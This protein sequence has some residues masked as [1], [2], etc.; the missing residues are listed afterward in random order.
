LNNQEIINA[1]K[2]EDLQDAIL[3]EKKKVFIS[4][5]DNILVIESY[6]ELRDKIEDMYV[7]PFRFYEIFKCNPFL[8]WVGKDA[9]IKEINKLYGKRNML[10]KWEPKIWRKIREEI[11][12]LIGRQFVIK[13]DWLYLLR[14]EFIVNGKL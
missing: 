10:I 3:D 5:C 2:I 8:Y 6:E 4:E 12:E 7:V 9:D 11:N 1:Q 14:D 13:L